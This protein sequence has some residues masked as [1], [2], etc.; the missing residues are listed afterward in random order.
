VQVWSRRESGI[1]GQRELG[2]ALD[3]L[4]GVN[5]DPARGEVH[6]LAERA[7]VLDRGLAEAGL[8]LCD[9]G[10]IFHLPDATHW[11]QHEESDAVNRRLIKFLRQDR[12]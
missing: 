1:A 6:V 3:A 4:T 9:K 8:A 7:V 2:P 10:E 5:L 12:S 11:L